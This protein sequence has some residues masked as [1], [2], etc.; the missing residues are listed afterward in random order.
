MADD[1]LKTTDVTNEINNQQHNPSNEETNLP[2]PS[3]EF[4]GDGPSQAEDQN[5]DEHKFQEGQLLRFIK[6]RFP[7]NAKSFPFLIGNKVFS[8]GQ[9]V[10]AMSDRGMDIG[11]INSFP[12]EVKFHKAMSPIKTISKIATEDDI[13]KKAELSSREKSAENICL[14]LIEKYNLDMVL[15][16]VEI[17]QFGKK[18]V[19]YF[20]APDRVDFRNLVK[21]LVAE[22]KMRIEL[23]QISVR[24]RS[25][26]LGAISACGRQ[27]CCSSFL[28]NYGTVNIKMAKNQNISIIPVKLNGVCGQV[29]CC[30]RFE[31]E[32]YTQK[33][34][35]LPKE[36]SFIKV[37]NGDI[38]K[39]TKL[40][41][42]HEEFEML[43]D[44]GN[45]RRY[46]LSQ[47]DTELPLPDGWKF[48]DRF[49]HVMNE[50]KTL[51][52]EKVDLAKLKESEIKNVV[53]TVEEKEHEQEEEKIE[54]EIEIKKD[55]KDN[56][57]V[58]IENKKPTQHRQHRHKN[59]NNRNR[60]NRS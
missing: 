23:R 45:L 40:H 22:L 56:N 20:N 11:Y 26:A 58:E 9:K 46:A 21:D 31:N 25:A 30:V 4:G 34:K 16:H 7:G 36:G 5:Q 43:T 37:L 48:P 2:L 57:N 24:D 35:Y 12:Y 50:T 60:G 29:K 14:R 44:K 27:N 10:V 54:I 49:E 15:T 53:N 55:N 28:K 3:N 13:K 41:V 42:L 6:V 1:N 38:G 17:I 39:I 18:A 51:I 19:F 59:R 8:Y 47:Y 32:V 33:R 52:G